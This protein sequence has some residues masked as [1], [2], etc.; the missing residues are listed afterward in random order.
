MKLNNLFPN[1]K[2]IIGV[3]HLLPL[4]G[5]PNFNGGINLIIERA[6]AEV[7]TLK[8]GGVDGLIIENFHDV[9]FLNT[10]ITL[11]QYG[12]MASILTLAR[13][14]VNIPL[15]VNVHYNDWMSELT[16]AYVCKA[17][18]IRVEVFINTVITSSGIV[19]PCCAEVTRHRKM[20]GAENDIQ[21]WA[22][23]HPKYSKNLVSYTL[24]ESAK[25]AEEALADSLIVTGE[26]TGRETPIEDVK[27]VKRSSQLQV[28]VGS[29]AN[30]DN[31]KDTL[32]SADGIIVGSA[33]KISGNT[34]EPVSLEK[35][36][37]FMFAA[38]EHR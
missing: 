4:P 10:P 9:P 27:E 18:F 35:I 25:M 36:R 38:Q 14:E 13:Q 26:T 31:L 21:I 33:F 11:E 22:D 15:G 29:G 34:H 23:I 6:L 30:P 1:K 5:S 24:Q 32:S 7:K 20:I 28:F 2:P 37:E 3:V 19:E 16:L 17:Q 8:Q 12:L